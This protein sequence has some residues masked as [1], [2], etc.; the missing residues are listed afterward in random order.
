MPT[1]NK[2]KT[3]RQRPK[4]L[5]LDCDPGCDDVIAIALLLGHASTLY[6]AVDI[7]SVAGNVGIDQTTANARR[8][9]SV[10]WPE[11]DAPRIRLFRGC[12]RSLTG[13]ELPAADVHGRDG[14][15]DVPANMLD[16]KIL[17]GFAK[18]EKMLKAPRK[19]P[20]AISRLRN[21]ASPGPGFDLLCTGPLTNLAV[22]FTTMGRAGRLC[23]WDRVRRAVIMG[24]NFAVPGN[25]TDAA[26]FNVFHDPVAVQIVLD[27]FREYYTQDAFIK[28]KRKQKIA[29]SKLVFVPLDLTEQKCLDENK[30]GDNKRPLLGSEAAKVGFL[31]YAVHVYARFHALAANRPDWNDKRYSDRNRDVITEQLTGS[32]GVSKESPFF[33]LHDALAAWIL[34]ADIEPPHPRNRMRPGLPRSGDAI[35]VDTSLTASRGHIFFP[36]PHAHP[37]SNR[38]PDLGTAV[39]WFEKL[40]VDNWKDFFKELKALLALKGTSFESDG[41][42]DPNGA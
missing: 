39:H 19:E 29:R 33:F 15:G 8:V 3:T 41:S 37:I 2:T 35:R 36:R 18:A 27:A 40:T 26:E 22:A 24:G 20:C 30:I 4:A 21:F 9:L 1:G 17:P 14:L 25:V 16:E 28:D 32:S 31:K 38:P 23:F 6:Q 10:F 7:L 12:S 5:I 13:G 42:E 11:K 34:I